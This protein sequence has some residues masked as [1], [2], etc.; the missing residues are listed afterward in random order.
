VTAVN[1]AASV[2]GGNENFEPVMAE[3][4]VPANGDDTARRDGDADPW[5]ALVQLGAQ[6]IDILK[7]SGTSTA[8]PLF[9]VE[10][11]PA[12]GAR[13]LKIPLPPPETAHRLADALSILS[14]R[15]R[16]A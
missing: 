3:A 15:L 6:L 8:Q 4:I 11:D 14:D 16:S 9:Q 10:Q 13:S 12:T 1:G 2:D 5:L 7:P